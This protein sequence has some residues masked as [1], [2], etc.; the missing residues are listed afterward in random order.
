MLL[1]NPIDKSV[2]EKYN[3]YDTIKKHELEKVIYRS[4]ILKLY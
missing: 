4:K 1:P 2:Y 3:N